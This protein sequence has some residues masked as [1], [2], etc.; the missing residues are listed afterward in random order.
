MKEI[1]AEINALILDLS[2]QNAGAINV[3]IQLK[4][5]KDIFTLMF[6]DLMEIK[7]SKIWGLYKDSCEED[8]S[9]FQALVFAEV[10]TRSDANQLYKRESR[11]GFS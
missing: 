4:E 5:K 8:L 1:N 11:H 7:G 3:L 10:K 9:A 6:L 2:Q